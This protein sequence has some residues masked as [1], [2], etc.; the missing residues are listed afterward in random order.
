VLAGHHNGVI[1]AAGGANF[2]DAMPWEGGKKKTYDDVYVFLPHEGLWKPAG[3]LPEPRGYA[4]VVSLPEGVLVLGGENAE[5]VFGDSLWLRWNGREVVVS[6]GPHLPV[7][8]TSAVAVAVEGTVYLAQGY[9]AGSP[10]LSAPG[11]W[12]WEVA[13]GEAGWEAL[14]GWDGPSR[15]QAVMAAVAD[16]I[17]LLSGIELA[18]RENGKP[19]PHYLTDAYRYRPNQ[20]VWEPLPELPHSVVAAPT[21]APVNPVAGRFFVLGGVDGRNV[22]KQPRETRVPDA[23][24]SFA[25]AEN[26]WQVEPGRW[27]SPVVTAPAFLFGDEWIFVSGEM[28]AGV[29]TPEVWAWK[30]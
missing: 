22:G 16:D 30:P 8:T 3:R 23:I 4:A 6:P 5:R 26:R 10:R 7:P 13:R 28:R 27:P 17:Y 2:P 14:P 12:R 20:R 25:P 15:G 21:P 24:L 19:G 11:F 29:R 9:A 1:L 18:L